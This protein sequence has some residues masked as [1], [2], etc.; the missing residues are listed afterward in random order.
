MTEKTLKQRINEC[1]TVEEKNEILNNKDLRNEDFVFCNLNGAN[2]DGASLV[3]ANLVGANLDSASLVGANLDGTSLVGANLYGA[4]LD[5]AS[6]VGANIVRANLVRASLVRASLD[7][8]S[9]VRANLVHANL[10]GASLDGANLVR[11]SLNICGKWSCS[12]DKTIIKIGCKRMSLEQ[13]D[14]FFAGDEEFETKRGTFEFFDIE[15]NYRWFKEMLKTYPK[16]FG[17]K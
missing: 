17:V 6:L 2:L 3:R 9:L 7:G 16:E 11:A 8:A 14:A 12:Y 13:W 1:K 10:D 15:H 4:N 5:G